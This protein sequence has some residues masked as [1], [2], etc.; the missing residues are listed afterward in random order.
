MQKVFEQPAVPADEAD[1][2]FIE[3]SGKGEIKLSR[4]ADQQRQHQYGRHAETE[5]EVERA[6]L[7]GT[8]G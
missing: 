5:G 2:G 7:A 6:A 1:A 4:I 8:V 3:Q